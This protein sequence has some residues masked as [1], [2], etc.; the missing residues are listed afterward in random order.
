M[1]TLMVWNYET[2]HNTV[3]G[4]TWRKIATDYKVGSREELL[5]WRVM[6]A[7][8]GAASKDYFYSPRDY[9]AFSGNNIDMY[10][11]QI[12]AW[13]EQHKTILQEI[14]TTNDNATVVSNGGSYASFFPTE[15][16]TESTAS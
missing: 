16:L 4:Y 3:D 11:E 8:N 12:D 6:V 15:E 9:A 14:N 1:S 5:F 2:D 7:A 10:K 13:S